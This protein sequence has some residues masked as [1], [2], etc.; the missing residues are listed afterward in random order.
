M[1][2]KLNKGVYILSIILFM[3]ASIWIYFFK[4]NYSPDDFRFLYWDAQPNLIPFSSFITSKGEFSRSYL[5]LSILNIFGFSILGFL[6]AF[7]F[8][9]KWSQILIPSLIGFGFS[10]FIELMQLALKFGGF[11]ITDIFFNTLGAILGSLIYALVHN[12]ISVYAKNIISLVILTISIVMI[13]TG[14]ISTAIVWP[15]YVSPVGN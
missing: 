5:I 10:L 14:V 3:V 6:F 11:E 15:I 1:K 2:T 8:N 7:T 13:V 9:K 12:K 4:C